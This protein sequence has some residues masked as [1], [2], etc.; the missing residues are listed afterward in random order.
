M[1]SLYVWE[2]VT[3]CDRVEEDKE[4]SSIYALFLD[5]DYDFII[6]IKIIPV[7]CY[8]ILETHFM[9]IVISYYI[10]SSRGEFG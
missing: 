10:K 5:C 1:F 4:S 8:A 2:S 9:H 6:A 7:V 3:Y